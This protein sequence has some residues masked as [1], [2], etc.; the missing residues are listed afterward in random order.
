M[1]DTRTCTRKSGTARRPLLPLAAACLLFGLSVCAQAGVDQNHDEVLYIGDVGDDTVRGFDSKTGAFLGD[2]VQS[3][4]G[5]LSGP[6]GLIFRGG[7]LLVSN[8]NFGLDNGEVLR[9]DR[10]TGDF[11]NALVPAV[12]PNA[13][14]APRGLVRAPHGNAI[15]VADIGTQGDDCSNQGR[16]AGYRAS[17]GQYLGDLDRSGFAADFHPRGLVV[18]PDGLLYVS[19]IGC[20]IPPDSLFDPLAGYVLRFDPRT[21][22]FVDV[23]ASNATIPDLHRP[24][25][26]VFDE[27]GDLWVTSF[28]ADAD[29]N[30]K[31]LKLSGKTG[32]LKRVLPLAAPESSGG[33]RAYAQAILFGPRG[34]LFIPITGGDATTA[35]EVRRCDVKKKNPSCQVLVP[36]D[37]TLLAPF[38]LIFEHT[39]PSTLEFED[40]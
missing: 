34:D 31:I 9:F 16:V 26:L 5:G 4:S 36:A 28:R 22:K 35:G 6:M 25:G 20:P 21:G 12:D 40:D 37:G 10:R 38:Y 8:Q 17:N 7:K 23:F 1:N 14:Y 33:T 39:D 3:G 30:D 15:Y 27:H 32:E 18:G 19:A 11:V 2:F 29:D 24:E 13:P